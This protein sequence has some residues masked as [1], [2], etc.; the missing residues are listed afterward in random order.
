[1]IREICVN[2]NSGVRSCLQRNSATC[3]IVL[4]VPTVILPAEP[5]VSVTLNIA[6]VEAPAI[7][8]AA[9]SETY[10]LPVVLATRFGALVKI[11]APDV[12]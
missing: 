6:P 11:F 12:L 7:V 9:E 5:A 10:T 2:R 8:V 1:M 4:P 3:V